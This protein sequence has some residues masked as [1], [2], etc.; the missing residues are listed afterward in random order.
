MATHFVETP[1]LFFAH[2]TN[3]DYNWKIRNDGRKTKKKKKKKSRCSNDGDF[4][5]RGR[6]FWRDE[7][8]GDSVPM[9]ESWQVCTSLAKDRNSLEAVQHKA[10]RFVHGDY[11]RRVS[12]T[13]ILEALGWKTLEARR[14]AS[15]LQ[16]SNIQHLYYNSP[17]VCLSA[18]AN[19]RSQ[20]LL[21][22]LG[23][24]L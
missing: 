12:T 11:R 3:R 23:R 2:Y 16:L 9:T 17:Y 19:C 10:A 24:C 13:N 22:R 1:S 20:F 4:G 14:R 5:L 15:R 7:N 8:N 18:F 6:R 21:D